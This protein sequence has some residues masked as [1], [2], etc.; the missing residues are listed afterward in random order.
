MQ[1]G[2]SREWAKQYDKKG[3]DAF[4]TGLGEAVLMGALA[5]F[6]H[7]NV[8][9]TSPNPNYWWSLKDGALKQADIC[10][11]LAGECTAKAAALEG[12]HKS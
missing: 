11:K 5:G 9:Y 6:S 10:Q 2:Y 4:V 12:S 1:V 8:T 3:N 7:T